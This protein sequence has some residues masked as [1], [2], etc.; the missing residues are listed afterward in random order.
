VLK[1]IRH[2]QKSLLLALGCTI[3]LFTGS[4]LSQGMERFR[5]PY[6]FALALLAAAPWAKIAPVNHTYKEMPDPKPAP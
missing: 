3:V 4:T 1:L 2:Q 6:L 5:T